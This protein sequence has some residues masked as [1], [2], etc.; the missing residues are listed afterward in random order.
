VADHHLA[1]PGSHGSN[2]VQAP[3]A[4]PTIHVLIMPVVHTHLSA[5]PRA[6]PVPAALVALAVLTTI[7]ACRP[8]CFH[9]GGF[10]GTETVSCPAIHS[11]F[12]LTGTDAP[13]DEPPINDLFRRV[14]SRL[15]DCAGKPMSTQNRAP[16]L[17]SE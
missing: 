8:A 13:D 15:T 12:S 4:A 5:R 17:P 11:T 2:S 9:H 14:M 1:R 3:P 6:R 7:A 10:W 16:A